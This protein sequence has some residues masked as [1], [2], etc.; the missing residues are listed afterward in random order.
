MEPYTYVRYFLLHFY[1]WCVAVN[2]TSWFEFVFSPV[3]IHPSFVNT[4]RNESGDSIMANR[5]AKTD[6]V[7][8]AIIPSNGSS[9][10]RASMMPKNPQ[11]S[12]GDRNQMTCNSGIQKGPFLHVIIQIT[13]LHIIIRR[14]A[15]R[16]NPK[17]GRE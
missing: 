3:H 2:G 15:I 12:V 11:K 1:P 7:R 13:A 9:N 10:A 8:T 17:Q 14:G 5:H 4:V 6:E 16:K